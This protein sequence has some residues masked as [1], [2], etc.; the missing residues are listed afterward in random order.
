MEEQQP[1]GSKQRLDGPPSSQFPIPGT[2]AKGLHGSA[3]LCVFGGG[4]WHKASVSDCVPLA[5]P[6]GLSP[7]LILTPCGPE[8]VLVVSHGGGGCL[9]M[10]GPG[11]RCKWPEDP[12]R[13][14]TE[15][16]RHTARGRVFRGVPVFQPPGDALGSASA[17]V[18]VVRRLLADR[19][20]LPFPWTLSL[21][22][23]WCP[24]ASHH[25]LT[26]LFLHA[27]TFPLPFP[28][29]SLGLSLRR[30]QCPSASHHSFPSHSLARERERVPCGSAPGGGTRG[31]QGQG[32]RSG[33][34]GFGGGQTC[35][36][37]GRSSIE[38]RE[39]ELPEPVPEFVD[40]G[41]AVTGDH[42]AAAVRTGTT[43]GDPLAD[44]RVPSTREERSVGA[45]GTAT[46]DADEGERGVETTGT[47]TD[48]SVGRGSSAMA[49][50]RGPSMR[51]G[52]RGQTVL[53]CLG[54][55]ASS[56]HCI[57]GSVDQQHP[58]RSVSGTWLSGCRALGHQVR[59]MSLMFCS[60]PINP[61]PLRML[62]PLPQASPSLPVLVRF[63]DVQER[64][65]TVTPRCVRVIANA[66]VPQAMRHT[67]E[68]AL[69]GVRPVHIRT[70]LTGGLRVRRI[71]RVAPAPA[72]VCLAR[73]LCRPLL[74]CHAG[75]RTA[76]PP[77][78]AARALLPPFA[79]GRPAAPWP[80]PTR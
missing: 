4:C 45:W 26:F 32:R 18:D 1:S 36:T 2:C 9:E 6:I 41:G 62:R 20:S 28:F 66:H 80:G 51:S 38:K 8:R 24:S 15:P 10:Q 77:S 60:I 55:Q 30:P 35:E 67:S 29:P 22:R 64:P 74:S 53:V 43:R 40:A 16:P 61:P 37:K 19:H 5:A 42:G 27:L 72:V 70:D 21:H 65:P 52:I 58:V 79:P 59:T 11:N 44:E 57:W 14:H 56:V 23:R 12:H 33:M 78:V 49:V 75:V 50:G 3:W 46:A 47:N 7:L 13:L 48:F 68:S 71:H 63:S 69:G 73:R 31:A 54:G 25:P 17:S 39:D 76:A 34:G